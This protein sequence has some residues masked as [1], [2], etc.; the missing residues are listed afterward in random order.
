MKPESPRARNNKGQD[1]K[2]VER[3]TFT[4]EEAAEILG[5]SRALAYRKGVLPTVRIAGRRLVPKRALER[6]LEKTASRNVTEG[7]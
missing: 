7:E 6:M 1:P 3:L 5:I 2:A 4:V